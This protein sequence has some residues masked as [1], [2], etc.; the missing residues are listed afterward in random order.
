MVVERDDRERVDGATVVRGATP[1]RHEAALD[2]QA[3]CRT[4]I[5]VQANSD[6]DDRALRPGEPLGLSKQPGP[7]ALPL[8]VREDVQVLDLGDPVVAKW[9][10]ARG[11]ANP[12]IPRNPPPP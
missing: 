2:V 6:P 12:P 7:D 1:V 9:R 5:T 8:R 4:V 3:L 11:P 10:A